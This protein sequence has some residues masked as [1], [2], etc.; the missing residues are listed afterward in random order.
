MNT[1]SESSD[2]ARMRSIQQ[3]GTDR[4]PSARSISQLSTQGS[5][6]S[7]AALCES[8]YSLGRSSGVGIAR[9]DRAYPF[10]QLVLENQGM[11]YNLAYRILG[12]PELAASATEDAFLRAFRAFPGRRGRAPELW[13]TRIVVTTCQEQLGQLPV[14]DSHSR[15]PLPGDYL[16]GSCAVL[17]DH[18]KS[19][20]HAQALLNTLPPDQR[21]ALVLSDVQGLS[22]REIADVT[23]VSVDM[24]RS[25]L[26]QGR[27]TLR[28][29]LLAKG[30]SP[31]AD[32]P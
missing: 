16:E 3:H 15:S 8:R 17:L 11:V 24:I 21:V 6:Q 2:V 4:G 30:E 14:Q 28:N 29:A 23:G 7:H 22:Y 26:S 19:V 20:D 1:V 31:P 32:Q 18:Q 9:R 25:R 27:T 5:V 13:I 10:S 12:D